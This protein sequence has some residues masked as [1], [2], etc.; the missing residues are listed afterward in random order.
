MLTDSSILHLAENDSDGRFSRWIWENLDMKSRRIIFLAKLSFS[1]LKPKNILI[2]FYKLQYYIYS[3]PA[4]QVLPTCPWIPTIPRLTPNSS[5]GNSSDSISL[6]CLMVRLPVPTSSQRFAWDTWRSWCN[7]NIKHFHE[8]A[9]ARTHAHTCSL[10]WQLEQSP[11]TLSRS[12]S[13]WNSVAQK[14]K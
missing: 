14:N 5:S 3:S 11:W 7:T 8:H 4:S 12:I 10:W 9:G 6:D 2:C 1:H 13:P